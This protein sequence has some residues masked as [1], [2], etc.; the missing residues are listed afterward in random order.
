MLRKTRTSMAE[1][2]A[3]Y[4]A[5]ATPTILPYLYQPVCLLPMRAHVVQ[6]ASDLYVRDFFVGTGQNCRCFS[7]GGFQELAIADQAGHLKAWHPRLASTEEL[8]RPAQFKIQFGNLEAIGGANH[9]VE[10]TFAGL[11]NFPAG[12]QDAIRFG[13]AA[14]DA[15]AK[16]V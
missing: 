9:G 8:A 5:R 1:P 15:S 10:A 11:G 16:L 4:A 6:G 3:S 13:T 7:L 12:Q 14:A 2:F